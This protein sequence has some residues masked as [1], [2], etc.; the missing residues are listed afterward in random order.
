VDNK[1]GKRTS[2][3]AGSEDEGSPD[4]RS[5]E[6]LQKEKLTEDGEC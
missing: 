4:C 5:Q 1:T 6:S 2:L 3:R